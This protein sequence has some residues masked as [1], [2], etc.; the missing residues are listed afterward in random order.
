MK[1]EQ[2][3]EVL[4]KE[5][6]KKRFFFHL[7]LSPLGVES[8]SLGQ[9]LGRVLAEE[10]QAGS[11]VP[12]FDRSNVDG[13]ALRAED[14]FG[15]DENNLGEL[16]IIK[17]NWEIGTIPSGEIK[18][19]QC[20][21]IATGGAVPRGANSVVMVE[22]T[23]TSEGRL[24]LRKPLA[25]GENI[26]HTGSDISR[27]EVIL[28]PFQAVTSREI[29][30]LAALGVKEICVFKRPRVAIYSTGNELIAPGTPL[31]PGQVH[32]CNG[33]LLA[34]A[35]EEL[36]CLGDCRGILKDNSE[37][38]REAIFQ[39]LD[40]DMILLSGGTSKGPSDLTYQVLN[41]LGKP[42]IVV[43]GV[44]MKPGKPLCLAVFYLETEEG[45]PP[46]LRKV[47][48]AILPGFPTSAIMTFHEFISPVLRVFSGRKASTPQNTLCKVSMKIPSVNGRTDFL[49][50]KLFK[51]SHPDPESG[52]KAPP[53]IA[54]PVGK[55][56]GSITSFSHAD[57]FIEIPR[58][59]EFLFPGEIAQVQLLTQKTNL[60]DW[61]IM[62][63]HCPGVDLLVGH[64]RTHGLH[65]SF[66]SLGSLGGLHAFR[67]GECDLACI[68]LFDSKSG[69]YN[70]PFLQPGELLLPGYDRIQGLV[71]KKNDSRF[72]ANSTLEEFLAIVK[73]RPELLLANRNG[74]S[75]TR[76]LLDSFL[77]GFRPNGYFNELKSHHAVA[78]S[79][80]QG[81]ADWG[82]A[83]EW[84]ADNAGLAFIPVKA[85]QF[86]FVINPQKSSPEKTQL[87]LAILNST[88]YQ[89]RLGKLRFL[90]RGKK[91]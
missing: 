77:S 36:G 49:P 50:V 46:G 83:V 3:L 7:D 56:S 80:V 72:S 89:E 41:S 5:E 28:H 68:H 65:A 91:A 53:Y 38:I 64:L 71:Y 4:S 66:T 52:G 18:N 33:P 27:G 19:G 16:K 26:S 81:R 43:H 13:F 31:Q 23:E 54:V 14:T 25:P 34:A 67:R 88:V 24:I 75:G 60:A 55:G 45:K 63:S 47:P 61:N 21:P 87:V 51:N 73:G 37:A 58:H 1:Q 11:D 30:V 62:G 86:D 12:G 84:F 59:Q 17:G 70:T 6:A 9:V 29:G 69:E 79:I 44:A 32:D 20:A 15:I 82:M 8:V 35:V 10:C 76:F 85:E 78:Q 2:F 40:C 22:Q 90:P 57:G 39:S 42:G 48:V 74:G